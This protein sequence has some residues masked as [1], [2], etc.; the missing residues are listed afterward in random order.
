[1]VTATTAK[2]QQATNQNSKQQTAIATNHKNSK[3]K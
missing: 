1:V 2:K 3:Q